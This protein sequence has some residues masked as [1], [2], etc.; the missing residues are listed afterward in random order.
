MKKVSVVMASYLGDYPGRASNPEKKLV[1]AV[2]S[3]LTQTY[4]NKELI[5]VSDGCQNTV[6]IYEKIFKKFNNIKLVSIEKQPVYSGDCR[7]AG[8]DIATGDIITYLDNDDLLGKTHLELIMTQFTDDVDMVYYDDFLVLSPDFKKLQQ[9]LVE[10]RYGSIG[11]S[12]ISH[13]NVDWLRWT[14]GYGHDWVFIQSAIANGML[15]KKL[16]NTPQYLVCHWGG[17]EQR[18]DF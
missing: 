4:D 10:V 2:K 5:I 9:R 12:A 13:R 18:G 14:V 1:R 6:K 15:F 3:F 16:D 11:T 17:G 8:M 7:N